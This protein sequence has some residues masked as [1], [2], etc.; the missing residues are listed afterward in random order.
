M[1]TYLHQEQVAWSSSDPNQLIQIL[2]ASRGKINYGASLTIS[3]GGKLIFGSQS[4]EVTGPRLQTSLVPVSTRFELK[5]QHIKL[6]TSIDG[7]D[8]FLYAMKGIP[9]TFRGVFRNL[10]ASAVIDQ[11]VLN[12]QPIRAS[13]E[14]IDDEDNP[15]IFTVFQNR[16]NTN[17]NI[18]LIQ[19]QLEREL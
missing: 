7:N 19:L 8:I 13:W 4:T 9:L 14:V 1:L 15:N 17:T 16:G 10:R 12:G 3:S 6:K 18:R 5:Y 11:I 2:Q